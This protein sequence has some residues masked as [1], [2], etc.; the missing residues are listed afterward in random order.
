[1]EPKYHTFFQALILILAVMALPKRHGP[2]GP[3]ADAPDEQHPR[4]TAQQPAVQELMVTF[5]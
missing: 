4:R 2:K 5:N 3:D 1:M